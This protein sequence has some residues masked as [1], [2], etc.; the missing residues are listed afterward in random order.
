VQPQA[1]FV[2]NPDFINGRDQPATR[3]AH[4]PTTVQF[5]LNDR[6]ADRG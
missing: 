3:S 6:A 5:T 4:N 2:S 1:K